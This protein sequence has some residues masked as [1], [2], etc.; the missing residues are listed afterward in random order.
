MKTK[1]LTIEAIEQQQLI[2]DMWAI[3]QCSFNISFETFQQNMHAFDTY[4]L[5][6]KKSGQLVGFSGIRDG[7]TRLGKKLYR[8]VYMGHFSVR[9]EFRGKSLIPL[10]LIKLFVDHHLKFRRGKL[11][12]WGDAGTYK[13]YL[14]MGKGTKY[15]YPH[16]DPAETKWSQTLHELS[17]KVGAQCVSGIFDP[18]RGIVHSRTQITIP[19]EYAIS[20]KDLE[21]P[22]INYYVQRNPGY[23]AGDGLVFLCPANFANL[24]HYMVTKGKLKKMVLK[25]LGRVLPFGGRSRKRAQ[26]AEVV[27]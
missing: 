25:G 7:Q 1:F 17:L 13:S 24:W 3:Y 9:K 4:A 5:F 23:G 21:D 22:L 26:R 27:G 8:T 18:A 6:F 16:P 19:Q 20:E 10:A 15:F 14:V 11:I 2:P 12:V